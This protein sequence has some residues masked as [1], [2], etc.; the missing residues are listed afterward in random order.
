[1]LTGVGAWR[2]I[3]LH[4]A[5]PRVF[6]LHGALIGLAAQG[7]L[8]GATGYLL[9]TAA[10]LLGVVFRDAGLRKSVLAAGAQIAAGFGVAVLPLLIQSLLTPDDVLRRWGT[11]EQS[12]SGF[13]V[14]MKQRTFF[15]LGGLALLATAIH[16]LGK[17]GDAAAMSG[18]QRSVVVVLLALVA[19]AVVAQPVFG[20]L[21]KGIQP[22]HFA[23]RI[24]DVVI[25]SGL[26]LLCMLV[27]NLL[28]GRRAWGVAGAL[29][30]CVGVASG[31]IR[32]ANREATKQTQ[33]RPWSGGFPPMPS[34]RADLAGLVREL[35]KDTYAEATILGTF[36]QQLAMWW[37]TEAGRSLFIPDTFLSTASD[38]EIER[39]TVHLSRLVG[40]TT[41]GF[42]QK[43]N[44][45]Y[46]QLRFLGLGKWQATTNYVPGRTDYTPEQYA[47]ILRT[48]PGRDFWHIAVPVREQQRLRTRF[49]QAEPLQARLDLIVLADAAS[50]SDLP[51]P[52]QGFRLTYRNRSFRIFLRD[53]ARGE[54]PVSP[55]AQ[56]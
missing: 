32:D 31:M 30:V 36:D 51:G 19:G 21:G 16:I 1:M 38:E 2:H 5:D 28:G 43:V 17:R 50:F 22:H 39:R 35:E 18:R 24:E 45:R 4:R 27:V 29:L 55:H 11:F 46:F 54:D 14:Y 7:D 42:M 37:M 41:D 23:A 26:V 12:R 15:L 40:F 20:I 13:V 47:R 8:H 3:R 6:F 9:A 56:R 49:E 10:L 52:A 53:P 33:P 25:L 44:D 48:V 34:Y